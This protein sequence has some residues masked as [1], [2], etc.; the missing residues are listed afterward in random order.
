M[1]P[2]EL[3]LSTNA[4]QQTCDERVSITTT[5]Q[6][7]RRVDT[8]TRVAGVGRGMT[9]TVEY[10]HFGPLGWFF[11]ALFRWISKNAD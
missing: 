7:W 10:R 4:A 6:G 3:S 8:I 9:V 11:D 1:K 2:F 5:G